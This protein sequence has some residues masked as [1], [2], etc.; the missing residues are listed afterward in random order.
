MI[1]V[2]LKKNL[3]RFDEDDFMIREGET[4]ELNIKFLKFMKLK[5]LYLLVN[6]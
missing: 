3:R 5:L 1:K 2:S 4:K 6:Y